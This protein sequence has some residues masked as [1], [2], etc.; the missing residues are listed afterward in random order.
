MNSKH[1][2][3]SQR[4]LSGFLSALMVLTLMVSSFAADMTDFI[5]IPR[6]ARNWTDYLPAQI[7]LRFY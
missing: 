6:A 1:Y 4:V 2:S 5:G 3:K 7:C